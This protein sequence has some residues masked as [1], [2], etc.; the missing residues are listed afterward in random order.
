[1]LQYFR[2]EIQLKKPRDHTKEE[3]FHQYVKSVMR[4]QT[5]TQIFVEIAIDMLSS[6]Q[7]VQMS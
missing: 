6:A 4:A 1:M 3:Y 7:Y 2:G 5:Q